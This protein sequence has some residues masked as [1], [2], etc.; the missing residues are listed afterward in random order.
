M[1][2]REPRLSWQIEEY[3]HRPKGPDWFWALGVIALAGAAI[4]IIYHNILFAIFIIIAALILGFYAAREPDIIDIVISDDGIK[5]RKYFYQFE[6]IKGFGIDEHD[7]GN[8]LII[9][10][11]RI[12]TPFISI[13]LPLT[14]DPE[15]LRSLLKS[16][17]T[18]K[19]LKEHPSNRIMEHLGF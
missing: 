9:E 3:T 14:I 18:E 16:K 5:I 1:A 4:A 13:A 10:S 17:I 19:P 6:K 15:E 2:K 12:V 11:D 7:L 8:H